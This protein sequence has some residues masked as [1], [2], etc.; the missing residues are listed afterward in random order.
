MSFLRQSR[1][2]HPVLWG[3]GAF[4]L[5]AQ[6][7]QLVFHASHV[8]QSRPLVAG[9]DDDG[10]VAIDTTSRSLWFLDN[11]FVAYGPVYFRLAYALN[12]GMDP[13]VEPGTL[14]VA[15][16]RTKAIHFS[17][18][19]VSVL[20][21][22]ALSV[23]L[24]WLV[25][26]PPLILL[27]AS[28]FLWTLLRTDPWQEMLLRAHPDHILALFVGLA[29]WGSFR[30]WQKPE[31]QGRLRL[32]AWLWGLALSTKFS[33]ILFLPFTFPWGW[34]KVRA[35]L[36]HGAIAY[37][38]LGFP[39][40]FNVP[41]LYRFLRFQSQFSQP[42]TWNS[43]LD[44]MQLWAQQF[45]APVLLV[46]LVIFWI[47]REFRAPPTAR[48]LLLR[49]LVLALG[50]FLLILGQNVL[51]PHRHYLMPLIAGQVVLSACLL[52]VFFVA[53]TRS[54]WPTV[55]LGLSAFTVMANV[56]SLPMG[57]R[58]HVARQQECRPEAQELFVKIREKSE[59]GQKV[60]G[61][62]YSPALDRMP[63]VRSFWTPTIETI[64]K[65]E[66]SVLVLNRRHNQQYLA[67]KDPLSLA[68]IHNKTWDSTSD[69]YK[70][71]AEGKSVSH[72]SLGAWTNT[73]STACGWDLWEKNP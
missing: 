47:H 55:V 5:T 42:A 13:L 10:A 70:V 35:Y 69:F 6:T 37:F 18:L 27:V 34:Q 62:P 12:L 39:Q 48:P 67:P 60:F 8:T 72:E 64:K 46:I 30:L 28:G 45:A 33:V 4:L 26:P 68:A 66:F 56:E 44:W 71:F 43:V 1:F 41:R 53:P 20:A 40:H 52:R 16:A 59:A 54:L 22:I 31:D 3:L 2:W 58:E 21:V 23:F 29:A 73:W 17:L 38:V 49:S 65:G 11:G 19:I 7:A 61:D 14:G 36:L 15:E 9:F 63:N 25:S 24:S 50:P 57:L 51:A 32:S